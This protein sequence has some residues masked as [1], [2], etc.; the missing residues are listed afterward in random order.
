M[1]LSPGTFAG[2]P[3]HRDMSGAWFAFM[4]IDRDTSAQYKN[5]EQFA[6]APADEAWVYSCVRRLYQSAQSVPLKV[7]VRAG[8]DLI[9]ADSEPSQAGD[10]LQY[11]LDYVNPVDM[12]GALLRAYTVASYAVWG[13]SFW[14]KTKGKYGGAPQELY[15]HRAPDVEV[16][17]DDGRTPVAYTVKTKNDTQVY[18]PGSVVPFKTPNLANPLRGLSPL[19]AIGAEIA[20]GKG[21]A[22]KLSALLDNDSIPPGYWQIPPTAEFATQDESLVRRTLRALRGPKQKGKV[23]IMPAGLEFKSIML[24]PHDAEMVAS[25][26]VSRMAV[27]A[28]LG[29]PLV[30]AGDD[31]KN[32]VYGNVR[33]AERVFWR[34]TM[35]TLL[36]GYADVVNNWLVPD[37]DPTR[38]KLIVAFDYS[39]VEALRPTWDVEMNTWLAM[40]YGQVVVP[41]EVRRHFRLGPDV[42]WG[43]RPIPRTQI[44][45][46]PDPTTIAPGA[47]P[48]ADPTEQALLPQLEGAVGADETD[49]PASLRSFGRGLYR[50]P[51]VRAF[52]AHGGPLDDAAFLG[53]RIPDGARALIESGLRARHSADQIAISLEGVPA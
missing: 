1:T 32:T 52:V 5:A 20:T 19:S 48:G 12:T 38:R 16:K 47:I 30:L 27:C 6:K 46:R 28:A 14:T 33:D 15:W 39:E 22:D 41:N 21:W 4:G 37:F 24:T 49:L 43:D 13:E 42:P 7:Y 31:D 51:A 9:P 40:V 23:P 45:L 50:Q 36:D 17:S 2:L 3:A 44:A 8:R 29:V 18:K 11:L 35:T 53:Q 25:R 34:G 10:D 26:K